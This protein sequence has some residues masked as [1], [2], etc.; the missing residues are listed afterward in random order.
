MRIASFFEEAICYLIRRGARV[1]SD[2]SRCFV[3][4]LPY[5]L[6]FKRNGAPGWRS[7]APSG[8]SRRRLASLGRAV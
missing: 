8:R 2:G 4:R 1:S 7:V 3:R 6:K 5:A